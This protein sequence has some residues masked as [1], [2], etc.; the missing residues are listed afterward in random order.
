M[1]SHKLS[2]F[3]RKLYFEVLEAASGEVCIVFLLRTTYLFPQE[4]KVNWLAADFSP[5]RA[6]YKTMLLCTIPISDAPV[7]LD[8]KPNTSV[9]F[10]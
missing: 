9:P 7:M 6:M 5:T 1:I 10:E 4:E 3:E 8:F 2:I